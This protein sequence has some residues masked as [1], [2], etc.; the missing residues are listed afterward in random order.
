[1]QIKVVHRILGKNV[2]IIKLFKFHSV[3]IT[4][5]V[6]FEKNYTT[7]ELNIFVTMQL[8]ANLRVPAERP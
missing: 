6:L 3:I 4:Y 1:M 2:V 5:K 8:R 7:V